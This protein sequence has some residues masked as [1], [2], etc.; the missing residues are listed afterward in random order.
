MNLP[1]E[2]FGNV[3][4]MHSPEE[5]GV[6]QADSF[7]AYVTRQERS[8]VV[9]DLDN[10]ESL[11]SAGLTALLDVQARLRADDGDLKIATGNAINRKILEVTRLDEHLEVF[12]SV[13]DAVKAFR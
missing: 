5:L 4:V 8:N 12:D 1:T 7:A 13:I 3:V 9:L 11:D 2:I 10:T 6:D